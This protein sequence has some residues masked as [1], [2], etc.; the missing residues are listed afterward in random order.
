[1]LLCISLHAKLPN[2][3]TERLP[4]N[5]Q[6]H[7]KCILEKTLIFQQMLFYILVISHSYIHVKNSKG[8]YPS[9]IALTGQTP[10]QEPQLT[11]TSASITCLPSISDI[12]ET[13]HS[14]VQASQ[15]MQ[16]SEIL[17]A[18]CILLKRAKPHAYIPS[19]TIIKQIL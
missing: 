5:L 15:L 19:I 10:A 16:A 6:L 12:A 11:Q 13:G 9:D 8:S 14:G 7:K 4:E 1:M 18:I 17:Y 3:K 2:R